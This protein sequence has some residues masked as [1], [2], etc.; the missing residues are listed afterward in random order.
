MLCFAT[1]A[2]LS[3]A[4]YTQLLPTK[5]AYR[6]VP[7]P[8]AA[9]PPVCGDAYVDAC[10]GDAGFS[11]QLLIAGGDGADHRHTIGY[12]TAPPVYSS[13]CSGTYVPALLPVP[14]K[15][16]DV[17]SRAIFMSKGLQSPPACSCLAFCGASTERQAPVPVYD[18][19][20]VAYPVYGWALMY[21]A[22]NTDSDRAQYC[23]CKNARM[24]VRECGERNTVPGAVGEKGYVRQQSLIAAL[25]T[26]VQESLGRDGRLTATLSVYCPREITNWSYFDYGLSEWSQWST[27]YPELL[28]NATTTRTAV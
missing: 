2:A 22:T 17:P 11:M 15:L 9:T 19:N 18:C 24:P 7:P 23:Q 27:H 20:G 13:N 5:P 21:P 3:V 12:Q 16:T 6:T 14:N 4:A 28:C 1:A 10:M 8:H 26:V 25:G